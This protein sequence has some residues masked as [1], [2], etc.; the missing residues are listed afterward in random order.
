CRALEEIAEGLP[1]GCEAGILD[2]ALEAARELSEPHLRDRALAALA[3]RFLPDRA[4]Q[5]ARA[6]PGAEQRAQALLRLAAASAPERRSDVLRET[7]ELVRQL[8]SDDQRDPLLE[9]LSQ[10]LP[11]EEALA[12][13]R[14][15]VEPAHR[16]SALLALARRLGQEQRPAV[17]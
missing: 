3:V 17:L 8:E 11:P 15:I 6:I 7:L 9:E 12:V 10:L 5:V 16:G 13:T 14:H 1:P 2:D 4:L